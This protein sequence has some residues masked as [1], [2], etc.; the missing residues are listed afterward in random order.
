MSKDS[1]DLIRRL[2]KQVSNLHRKE[3][4]AKTQLKKAFHKMKALGK[5]YEKKAEAKLKKL[6]VKMTAAQARAVQEVEKKVR[7]KVA[8]KQKVLDRILTRLEK[9]FGVKPE[10]ASYKKA[11]RAKSRKKSA[12]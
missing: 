2:K 11:K 7:Q 8:G 9:H 4:A 5:A 3:K 10:K 12:S 6:K 1:A